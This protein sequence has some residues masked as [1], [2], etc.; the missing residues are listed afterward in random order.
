M[1]ILCPKLVCLE[2]GKGKRAVNR[3]V[4]NDK[5]SRLSVTNLSRMIFSLSTFPRTSLERERERD[6]LPS[7]FSSLGFLC[8]S[9]SCHLVISR[10]L[11]VRY[12]LAGFRSQSNPWISRSDHFKCKP[13][14]SGSPYLLVSMLFSWTNITI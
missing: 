12:P 14:G 9:L 10:S 11:L 6:F 3:Q 7:P 2:L 1:Y 8:F 13:C 5:K 4:K